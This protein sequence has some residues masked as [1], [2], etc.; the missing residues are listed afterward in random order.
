MKHTTESRYPAPSDVI[1]KMFTDKDYHCRKMDAL[2]IDYDVLEAASDGDEFHIKVERRVP[3]E[4][5]GIVK[6]IMPSTTTVVN[7]ER[8]RLS[9]KSGSVHVDTKG[10]PLQ[11]SCTAQMRDEGDECVI[12]Y[13]WDI[14][15]K[16]PLGGGALEKFVAGDMQKREAAEIQAAIDLLDDYR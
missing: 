16:I 4:A 10:V 7:D 15:A 12:E 1:I 6:K 9:D 11:M 8:W 2:G 13:Q 14:K 3:V 5:S